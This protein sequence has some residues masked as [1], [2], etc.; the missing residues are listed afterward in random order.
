MKFSVLLPTRNRLEYLKYAIAS[1]INQEYDNWE[2]IVSDN[3]SDDDN[4]GY[5]RFLNDSRI[6][7]FRMHSV[8]SVTENWNNALEQ[9]TGE[10]IVMLGDD[11]CLLKG[12]FKT[13]L[14]LLQKHQYPE[15]VYTS[16]LNY[17]YP[18]VMP[19]SLQG[20]L[21]HLVYASF[22]AEKQQPFLLDKQEALSAVNEL[23]NFNVA[24]NFNM[25]HSL[26][27]RSLINEMQKYGKFYQSP[28]PDYYAT[29]LLLIKAQRILVVPFPMVVIGVTP[30]S[31]GYYYI[32][33]KEKQGVEFLNNNLDY[34]ICN[35]LSKRIID[36]TN[37]NISWLVA[38]ETI[39]QNLCKEL[40]LKVNY[41]KFRFLQVLQQCKQFACREG[42]NLPDMLKLTKKLLFWE[43]IAY[44]IPFVIAAIIRWHP[45]KA[46]RKSWAADMS[47]AFSH[48]SHGAPKK[49]QG[50]YN[51]IMDVFQQIPI[52]PQ[53]TT[54]DASS[55]DVIPS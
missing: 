44:L 11:D 4:E 16:A 24:V 20:N 3:N 34:S 17:V 14:D 7:Y 54:I 22:L 6:K 36:G 25:Q 5:I 49:I 41:R 28:Y 35:E 43:K 48:P 8:C 18:G 39:K 47:Y 51:N 23:F 19:N 27:S 1:V 33:N 38:M 21:M 40:P 46:Y 29:T 30:K 55:S 37:M 45:K 32:N 52:N 9:S 10:Y 13:S 53:E 15:M 26:V 12:Y 42:L 50:Q 31:F 2:I